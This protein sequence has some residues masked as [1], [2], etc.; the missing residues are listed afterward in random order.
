MAAQI[1]ACSK[2]LEERRHR[3]PLGLSYIVQT[4]GHGKF[5]VRPYESYVATTVRK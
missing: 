3:P 2:D 4:L 5:L 1:I